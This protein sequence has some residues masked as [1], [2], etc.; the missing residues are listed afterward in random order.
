MARRSRLEIIKSG[1]FRTFHSAASE[2]CQLLQAV[3]DYRCKLSSQC[4]PYIRKSFQRPLHRWVPAGSSW[5]TH[6]RRP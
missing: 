3:D 5:S 1:N 4:T 2:L 6:S